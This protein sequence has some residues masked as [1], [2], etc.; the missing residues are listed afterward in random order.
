MVE[1]CPGGGGGQSLKQEEE[2][3]YLRAV[4][5][6]SEEIDADVTCRIRESWAKQV[7]QWDNF[8]RTVMWSALLYGSECWTINKSQE[9]RMQTA[10]MR[11]P[12]YMIG[13]SSIKG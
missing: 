7:G 11:M 13:V 5:Q 2:F 3:R 10:E 1:I 12:L 6:I 4:V 8:Y 9:H